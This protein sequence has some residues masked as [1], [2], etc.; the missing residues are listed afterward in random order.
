MGPKVNFVFALH[1]HQPVG[2]FDKVME[3]AYQ[4]AY[5]PFL[6]LVERHPRIR[7]CLHTSGC[8]F[9]WLELH[10]PDYGERIRALVAQGRTEVLGGGFFE[11]IFPMLPE[12]DRVGQIRSFS[13]YLKKRFKTEP[14]GMWL[15]ER[16]WEQSLV[17]SFV[18]AGMRYTVLDD[19]HFKC[20]GLQPGELG[21]YFST[22]DEGRVF[23]VFP[24]SEE[25]RYSIPFR[26]PD[27]T[28]AVLRRF[29]R[30][31]G[32]GLV[33]YADDGEK[34]GVW[35]KTRK[36][37]YDNGWLERFFRAIED[38]LDW[39]N[40]LTFSEALKAMPPLGRI[41]L[42]DC[43][44]REMTEWA[45][46]SGTQVEY[47]KLVDELRRE[48]R[49]ERCAP[50]LRGGVWRN[51]RTKYPESNVMCAKMWHVSEQVAA[52]PARSKEAELARLELYRGQCNCAYWHGVFGGL[53][54]PHLRDSVYRRLIAAEEMAARSGTRTRKTVRIESRDLDMDG[55]EEVYVSNGRINC[56]LAPARGG[57][58]YELDVVSRRFNMLNTL[59]R[60]PEAYHG[61]VH[62]ARVVDDI[63]Q[64]ETIH[65][66]VL[67]KQP[68]LQNM[69]HYDR[70]ARASLI[71]HFFSPGTTPDETAESRHREEGN[72]VGEPYAVEI[73]KAKI[74]FTRQG[75]VT[76]DGRAWNVEVRKSFCL[77]PADSLLRVQYRLENRS[78]E[79]L[80]T[81]FGVEFNFSMLAGDQD[82]RYYYRDSPV[83]AAG[84]CECGAAAAGRKRLGMLNQRL[85]IAGVENFGIV[86]EWQKLNIGL[87]VAPAAVWWVF[88]IQTVSQSEGGFELVYQSSSVIPCWQLC[89]RPGGTRDFEI[90]LAVRETE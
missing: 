60:R 73:S 85:C 87:H 88:P 84:P 63:D 56:Y 12:R 48:G 7:F 47:E 69:L 39:I 70:H 57:I 13:Q 76:R 44:Y 36:H 50:F 40:L 66:M 4:D 37:V 79:E 31:D 28:L 64:V 83:C 1:N 54:L 55:N 32:K 90:V 15:P 10:H 43:S 33:V 14:T 23:S 38:N 17:E 19:Y 72:F 6:D 89:L 45:L 16:V 65:N 77:Q 11:P 8:L 3:S 41:Y 21:G 52:M 42:P 30:P 46:P 29:A 53:Y 78:G 68:G 9:E 86:D 34:F 61:K 75:R 26:E 18:D 74:D 59:A 82:N 51:F 20:A 25:L 35:P 80:T 22:E 67:A 49:F 81:V 5:R 24:I 71:D 58:L 62:L 2:N 27:Q